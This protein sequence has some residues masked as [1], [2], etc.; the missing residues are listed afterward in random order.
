MMGG[1]GR[2]A[3]SRPDGCCVDGFGRCE[4]MTWDAEVRRERAGS[5]AGRRVGRRFE[6][7]GV[8]D[9]R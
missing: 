5:R 2:G 3:E 4:A 9:G 7:W 6:G 1:G 8:R